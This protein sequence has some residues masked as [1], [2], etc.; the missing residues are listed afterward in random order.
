MATQTEACFPLEQRSSTGGAAFT[1]RSD[2]EANS[3]NGKN[4]TE[5]QTDQVPPSA[6][7]QKASKAQLVAQD[8][9]DLMEAMDCKD[10]ERE[11]IRLERQMALETELHREA[12]E[13]E[14]VVREGDQ[15]DQAEQFCMLTG[16]FQEQATLMWDLINRLPV[17]A[18]QHSTPH[19]Y[20]PPPTMHYCRSPPPPFPS[21]HTENHPRH[22]PYSSYLHQ[23]ES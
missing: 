11:R 19:H 13:A 3:Q 8:I 9:T 5:N 2:E 6:K 22:K 15:R 17:P 18:P 14:R 12:Q 16:M 20:C 1:E 4:G 7:R 23:L 21:F 10:D